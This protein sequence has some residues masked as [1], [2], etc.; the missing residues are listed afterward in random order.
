MIRPHEARHQ[1]GV[2][3]TGFTDGGHEIVH[4]RS[5]VP[6]AG[7]ALAVP[8]LKAFPGRVV[9]VAVIGERFIVELEEDERVILER[10]EGAT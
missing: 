10:E 6:D 1:D 8:S 3:G 5:V 7:N 2:G 9:Y 4:P